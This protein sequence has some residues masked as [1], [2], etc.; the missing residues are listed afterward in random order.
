MFL[1]VVLLPGSAHSGKM[2][3]QR[4]KCIARR[5]LAR[6]Q[7]KDPIKYSYIGKQSD[8]IYIFNA[9]YGAK[10]QDFFCKVDKDSVKILSRNKTFRRNISYRIDSEDCAVIDYYPSGCPK[11]WV[12]RCCIPKSVDE[13]KADKEA[14]FWSR[15]VPDLLKEDQQEAIKA[16]QNRSSKASESK[17]EKQQEE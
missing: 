7:C 8:N 14:E 6:A 1:A 4:A 17:Q 9:F 16:L 10:Y 3:E 2:E 5:A 11:N 13:K 12:I 15:P